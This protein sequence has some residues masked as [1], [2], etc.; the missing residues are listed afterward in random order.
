MC[1]KQTDSEWPVRLV[2]RK[3]TR[4]I[5]NHPG[6]AAKRPPLRPGPCCSLTG[7]QNPEITTKLI[8]TN[9]FERFAGMR[10]AYRTTITDG[11]I[12]VNGRGPTPQDAHEAAQLEWELAHPITNLVMYP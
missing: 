4:K 10:F 12:E 5:T 1:H 2:G 6:A 3:L 9:F 7:M 11:D 8:P